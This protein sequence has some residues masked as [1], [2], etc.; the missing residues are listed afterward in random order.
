MAA[1]QLAPSVRNALMGRWVV[2]E[3]LDTW[4]PQLVAAGCSELVTVVERAVDGRTRYALKDV[5]QTPLL[6]YLDHLANGLRSDISYATADDL[7]QL[8]ELFDSI[9][10]HIVLLSEQPSDPLQRLCDSLLATAV[11]AYQELLPETPTRV[12][13][14]TEFDEFYV[15]NRPELAFAPFAGSAITRLQSEQPSMSRVQLHLTV[16]EFDISSFNSL[17]FAI[18]HE[19]VCHVLQ[20]PWD[21]SRTLPDAA[22]RFAEGWMDYAALQLYQRLLDGHFGQV[23]LPKT[24]FPDLRR[25]GFRNAARKLHQA[26]TEERERDSAW[27]HRAMGARAAESFLVQLSRT[28]HLESDAEHAFFHLSFAINAST[29]T[30]RERERF[31]GLVH[32]G[33]LRDERARKLRPLLQRF[34]HHRDVMQLLS[35]LWELEAQWTQD[36][37][38]PGAGPTGTP[39]GPSRQM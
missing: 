33:L 24:N 8:G 12:F 7:K 21:D 34:Y 22:S 28:P 11:A 9:D 27:G 30:H 36:R 20:G 35:G 39:S 37:G 18:F 38:H 29:L 10:G 1:T 17:P 2:C 26:R 32:T 5:D 6:T 3:A 23:K 4:K 13:G 25:T 14:A 15:A 31:A 19:C 16:G